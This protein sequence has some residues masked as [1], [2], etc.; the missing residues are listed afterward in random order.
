MLNK[1]RRL[2][3]SLRV[4]LPLVN[5]SARWCLVSSMYRIWIS[6]SRFILSNNKSREALWVLDTCHRVGLRPLII[7]LITASLSWKTHATQHWDQKVFRLMESDQCWSTP[8]WCPLLVFV[9][10]C[11]IECLPTGFSSG[12]LLIFGFVGLVRWGVKYFN[13]WILKIESENPIHASTCIE[14]NHLSFCKNHVKQKS[15]SCTSNS[16]ARTC[17]FRKCIEFLLMLIS[18]LPRSPAKCESWNSP[19]L[20]CLA[21]FPTYTILFVFTR[22]MDVRDKTQ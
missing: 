11:L 22:V 21:V 18:S 17:D 15:V 10:A 9:F 8:E 7:I 5:M 12:S 3:H 4:K 2:F 6:E 20:H 19:S 1:W 14:R 16:L 13:H